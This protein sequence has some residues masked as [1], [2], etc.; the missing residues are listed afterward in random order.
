MDS[1]I[2]LLLKSKISS[3]LPSSVTVQPGLCETWSEPKL[4]VFSCAGSSYFH[5]D[6]TEDQTVTDLSGKHKIKVKILFKMAIEYLKDHLLS[7][8]K[9][10]APS[11]SKQMFK[12]HITVKDIHWVITVPAIWEDKAKLIMR[13]AAIE[14]GRHHNLSRIVGK[15]TMWF[16]NRSDT[17][18]AVQSQ[19]Q[20]G[21]L[22][23][24]I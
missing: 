22:K 4:L 11:K 5:Q 24:R 18:Q 6:L 13:E 1:T 8:L 23:F 19:K 16:P 3:F 21:I 2:P 17:N 20:A 15:P 14:V 10:K 9:A 12:P 7:T